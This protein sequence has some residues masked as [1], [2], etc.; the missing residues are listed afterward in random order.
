[1]SARA[2][3]FAFRLPSRTAR[4]SRLRLDSPRHKRLYVLGLCVQLHV[5]GVR[6]RCAVLSSW[7]GLVPA[8]LVALLQLGCASGPDA[9]VQ[10]WQAA[11]RTGNPKNIL[12]LVSASSRPLVAAMLATGAKDLVPATQRH[13]LEVVSMQPDDALEPGKGYILQ[14]RAAGDPASPQRDWVLVAEDGGFRLDLQATSLR[15]PWGRA[16]RPGSML[17]PMGGTQAAPQTAPTDKAR[18]D[19]AEPMPRGLVVP[20]AAP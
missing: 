10:Q 14:V 20:N 1:M 15:R 9:F 7:R 11:V 2:G 17:E 19:A 16:G 6:Q 3:L 8:L 18:E 12:P 13:A 4:A 5:E